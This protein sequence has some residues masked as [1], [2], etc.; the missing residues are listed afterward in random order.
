M[1]GECTVHSDRTSSIKKVRSWNRI[2]LLKRA[3]ISFT[4]SPRRESSACQQCYNSWKCLPDGAALQMC[5]K[6]AR[7]SRACCSLEPV[8]KG[9]KS[10]AEPLAGIN[11]LKAYIW[12]RLKWFTWKSEEVS[13]ESPRLHGLCFVR[14]WGAV[15]CLLVNLV[16]VFL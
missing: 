14:R 9:D 16:R 5:D 3:C 4:L 12:W 1:I 11:T 2:S 6:Q 13:R 15:F 10:P 8:W 7:L